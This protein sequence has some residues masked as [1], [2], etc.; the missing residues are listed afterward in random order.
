MRQLIKAEKLKIERESFSD[1]H[2]KFIVEPLERGYGVTLGNSLRRILLSSIPGAAVTSIKIDGV[3]HEFATLTGMKEDVLQVI[4]NLKKLRVR[5]YVDGEKQALIDGRGPLEVKASHIQVDSEVEIM[6]P[7]LHIATLND[8]KSRLSM[9]INIS[10]GRGYVEAGENKKENQP[11]GTIPIDSIFT[12]VQKV[13]Y[14]VVPARIGRKAS[15]D[16]L[17]IEISTDGTIGADEALSHAAR[18]LQDYARIFILEDVEEKKKQ[19]FKNKFLQM[20]VEELNLPT[21]ALNALKDAGIK[22]VRDIIT[23]EPKELLTIHNF[24]EKSLE[25][26]EKKLAEHNL[27]LKGKGHET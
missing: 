7:D 19:E 4:Q 18:I 25:K 20:G 24:G 26:L 2:G 10:P 11:I 27:R 14:E 23:R 5:L 21:L 3:T 1:T 22:T 13:K 16:C 6:N 9:Q 12:P 15:Y 8:E 17:I